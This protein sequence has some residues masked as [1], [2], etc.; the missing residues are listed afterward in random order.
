MS[1]NEFFDI[2]NDNTGVTLVISAV[3][4]AINERIKLKNAKKT[5]DHSLKSKFIGEKTL[6]LENDLYLILSKFC[7]QDNSSEDFCITYYDQIRQFIINKDLYLREE[8]SNIGKEFAEYILNEVSNNG[9]DLQKQ[10]NLLK[11]FKKIYRS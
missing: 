10:E 9:R 3:G 1:L 5:F 7:L 2:I 4:F 8:L 6:N 11:K